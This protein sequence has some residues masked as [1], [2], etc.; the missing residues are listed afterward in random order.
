MQQEGVLCREGRN[1]GGGGRITNKSVLSQQ[2][3]VVL[4]MHFVDSKRTKTILKKKVKQ[5]LSFSKLKTS[6]LF[7]ALLHFY[8]CNT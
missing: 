6:F 8:I 7:H 5:T 3:A 4:Q 2:S 1:G